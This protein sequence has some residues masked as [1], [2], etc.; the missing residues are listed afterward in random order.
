MYYTIY[1]ITNLNNGMFYIG[2]HETESL[3]DSYFGSGK[4]L[5][6]SVKKHGKDMFKKEI[7]F[8]FDNFEEMNNKEIELVTSKEVTNPQ[9]YNLCLGG[10]SNLVKMTNMFNTVTGERNSFPIEVIDTL[11][12]NW[13]NFNDSKWYKEKNEVEFNIIE[14]KLDSSLEYKFD[15]SPF[16]L[17]Y[18]SKFKDTKYEDLVIYFSYHFDLQKRMPAQRRLNELIEYNDD[19]D[20]IFSCM[21]AWYE[22][23]NNERNAGSLIAFITR[24]GPKEGKIRYETKCEKDYVQHEKMKQQRLDKFDGKYVTPKMTEWYTSKGFTIEEAEEK[25]K[26]ISTKQSKSITKTYAETKH[27][28]EE[29][30]NMHK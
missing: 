14:F 1:K 12:S 27:K 19:V 25:I 26:N 5:T 20:I 17:K 13:V 28:Q 8:V 9:C 4:W 11:D 10:Q 18:L 29:V 6:R 7:L 3:D 21:K 22:N 23:I 15:K 2:Q 16:R 24:F 30:L